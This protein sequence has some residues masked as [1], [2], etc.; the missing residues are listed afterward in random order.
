MK[1][2]YLLSVAGLFLSQTLM[3]APQ[4]KVDRTADQPDSVNV[5]KTTPVDTVKSND[6]FADLE[7]E[8]NNIEN[9]NS[10]NDTTHLRLGKLKVEVTEDGNEIKIQ[11]DEDE[12]EPYHWDWEDKHEGFEPHWAGFAF[13]PNLYGPGE[14]SSNLGPET[15]YMELNTNKSWEFSWNISDVG[16]NLINDRFGLVSG[17]GMKWNNYRFSNKNLHLNKG[18]DSLEHYFDTNSYDKSKLT[19]W[20]LVVPLMFEWNIPLHHE[21]FY[22]A[23]GVEGTLKLGA[24]TK[25][26]TS[27]DK[28]SKNRDDFYLNS[29]NYS[30]VARAGYGDWG[31]YASYGMTPLFKKNQGPELYPFAMGISL[32]F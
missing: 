32:N 24:H 4:V 16:I 12:S 14:F 28:T 3:A 8:L 9:K 21:D 31:F 2:I 1:T 17:V 7:N 13:G 19:V 22:I 10:K 23:A 25:M 11:K 15:R 30:L 5:A 18:A 26:V 6:E 29:F 20:S 27:D